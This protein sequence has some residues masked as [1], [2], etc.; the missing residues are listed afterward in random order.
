MNPVCP[1]EEARPVIEALELLEGRDL[2]G[3][4]PVV[5]YAPGTCPTEFAGNGEADGGY[6]EDVRGGDL[7]LAALD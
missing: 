4:G 7:R 5:G 2:A 1:E 3:A 6:F